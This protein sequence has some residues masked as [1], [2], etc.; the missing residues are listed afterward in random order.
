MNEYII[1]IDIAKNVD[2]TAIT[3]A[4]KARTYGDDGRSLS[5]LDV[6]DLQMMEH[7]SYPDLARYVRRLDLHSDLHG[8]NDLLVDSTGVGEA[9]CDC[10]ADIGLAP[11]RIIFTGGDNYSMRVVDTAGLASRITHN[12]PKN[13]LIDTLHLAMQQGRVRLADGIPFEQDIRKQFAH[14]VGK[15]SKNKNQIYG[16]DQDDIH[17]DIVCSFA[18]AAW[19]FMQS[20][21]ARG[22]FRFEKEFQDGGMRFRGKRSTVRDYDFA[23]TI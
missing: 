20:D 21:G 9:V 16:N 18:M 4:R 22:D 17:D 13:E 23:E 8:N 7:L 6:L 3:I 11:N 19:W 1:S 14:F 15:L 10:M 5:Y 12:V 2:R